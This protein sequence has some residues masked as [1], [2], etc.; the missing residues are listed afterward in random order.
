MRGSFTLELAKMLVEEIVGDGDR[1]VVPRAPLAAL[2]TTDKQYRGAAWVEREEHADVARRRDQ[3]FHVLVS[4]LFD[5][6][7]E[8][9]SE[10]RASALKDVDGSGD[11]LLLLFGEVVPPIAE[12][13]DSTSQAIS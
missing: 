8:R 3:F 5:R 4:R 1:P 6:V 9:A 7:H 13:V 12:L 11:G 2:V 10:A